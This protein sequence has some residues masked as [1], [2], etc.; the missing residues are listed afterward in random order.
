MPRSEQRNAE[1]YVPRLL[2]REKKA[3]AGQGGSCTDERYCYLI[4]ERHGG[5]WVR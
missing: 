2:L 3:K 4:D 1:Y 5:E